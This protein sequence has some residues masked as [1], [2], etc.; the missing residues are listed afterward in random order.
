MRVL[1]ALTD[2]AVVE[3]RTLP[4]DE[5]DL[6]IAASRW[7]V[8]AFDNLSYVSPQMSDAMCRLATG[9]GLGT[10]QLYTDDGEVLFDAKRP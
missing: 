7:W 10:R 8:L 6:A 9:G 3:L 4:K 1:V 2:P 5:R